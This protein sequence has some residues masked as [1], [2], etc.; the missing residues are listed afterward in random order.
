MPITWTKLKINECLN[1]SHLYTS[2]NLQLQPLYFVPFISSIEY[3]PRKS[4]SCKTPESSARYYNDNGNEKTPRCKMISF[5]I[6][7]SVTCQ[8]L[9]RSSEY[10]SFPPDHHALTHGTSSRI[11]DKCLLPQTDPRMHIKGELNSSRDRP[12]MS[13]WMQMIY[14]DIVMGH[15]AQG[16]FLQQIFVSCSLLCTVM[17]LW[18]RSREGVSS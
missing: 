18:F 1:S 17:K 10:A 2:P 4:V 6:P 8:T 3:N 5:V 14:P 15:R 9:V 11:F 12:V 13:E 16:A 7:Q